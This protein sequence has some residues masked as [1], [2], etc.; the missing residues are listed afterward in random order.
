MTSAQFLSDA[1][2]EAR[3]GFGE[4]SPNPAVG[5]LVVQGTDI[6]GRGTTPG[7]A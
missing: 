2:A 5:A 7:P 1:I 3:R 4:T 6:V